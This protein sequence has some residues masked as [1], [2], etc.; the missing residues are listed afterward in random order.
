[1]VASSGSVKG[2]P[3]TSQSVGELR[4]VDIEHRRDAGQIDLTFADDALVDPAQRVRGAV[5][6]RSFRVE[7]ALAP[8]AKTVA[9]N[10]GAAST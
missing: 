1:M 4:H 7:V 10:A 2:L 8:C 9:E 3:R 5:P 6:R